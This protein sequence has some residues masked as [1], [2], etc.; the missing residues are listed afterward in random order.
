MVLLQNRKPDLAAR[1]FVRLNIPHLHLFANLPDF[2]ERHTV[3][4][5]FQVFISGEFRIDPLGELHGVARLASQLAEVFHGFTAARTAALTISATP[6]R[7]LVDDTSSLTPETPT[8]DVLP[9]L[10]RIL[11]TTVFASPSA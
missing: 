8:L 1:T 4:F 7:A 9:A 2:R 11:S 6:L 3:R 10:A 5:D